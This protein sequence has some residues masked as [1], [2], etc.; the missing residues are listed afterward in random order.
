MKYYKYLYVGPS[1]R[2]VD[3]IKAKL[4]SRAGLVGKYIIYLSH[5]NNQV[6]IINGAYLK[7][8]YYSKH[9]LVI[10]G[11]A[12]DYNEALS[13]VL[14]MIEESLEKTG[15][16]FIKEYLVLKAKTKDFSI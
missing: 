7:L 4:N 15:K 10:V 1:I 16:P 5:G 3:K 8:P 14:K 12:G 2:F 11:I 6:E 13:L 9:G